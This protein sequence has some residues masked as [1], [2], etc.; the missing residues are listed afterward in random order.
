MRTVESPNIPFTVL[1]TRFIEGNHLV[2]RF[3][4]THVQISFIV[5]PEVVIYDNG[6]NLH[7][8]ILNREPH[9]FRKTQFLIDRFHW[10]NHVG[11][12][13]QLHFS[14]KNE[15]YAFQVA[16]AHTM[17]PSTHNSRNWTHK[18]LNSLMLSWSVQNLHYH[19]WTRNIFLVM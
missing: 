14:K 6:C 16:V 10:P 17:C 7:N 2:C 19:T 3:K 12:F 11:E 8:Y 15:F 1:F 5:A 13:L 18:L 9:F 4:T